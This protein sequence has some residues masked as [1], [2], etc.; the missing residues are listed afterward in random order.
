LTCDVEDGQ[1]NFVAD[2][3]P[4][5]GG[6]GLGPDPG[7]YGRAALA[8]CLAVGYVMWAARLD[9]P[10]N[11]VEVVV[12]ADYDAR[13]IYAVDE[14]ITPGW[15]AVRYTVRIE[16]SAPEARVKEVIETAD[17][18]SSILD[19]FKRPLDVRREVE[20]TQPRSA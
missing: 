11:S 16:S 6:A 19:A 5:D 8:S 13:G 20:L 18:Y 14:T 12:E 9:V 1:W 10:L 4:G 17:R 7:V 15:P 2:E 3:M